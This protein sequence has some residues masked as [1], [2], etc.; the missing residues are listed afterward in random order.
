MQKRSELVSSMFTRFANKTGPARPKSHAE[1]ARRRAST[2]LGHTKNEQAVTTAGANGQA[3][4]GRSKASTAG[5]T[6]RLPLSRDWDA[7]STFMFVGPASTCKEKML[8]M[9][10]NLLANQK[11]LRVNGQT[12]EMPPAKVMEKIIKRNA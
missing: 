2:A 8:H 3:E 11:G 4:I 10:A 9:R 6:G 1:A 12:H 5:V 7:Q